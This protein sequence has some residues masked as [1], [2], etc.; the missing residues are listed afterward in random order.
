ML[1]VGRLSKI[2]KRVLAFVVPAVIGVVAA[3][4][5]V[6]IDRV[7]YLEGPLPVVLL[8]IGLVVGVIAAGVASI[9]S[10]SPPDHEAVASESVAT[11]AGSGTEQRLAMLSKLHEVVSERLLAIDER[12]EDIT[13]DDTAVSGARH[14]L[15]RLERFLLDVQGVA[16]MH[17]VRPDRVELD[18]CDLVNAVIE[19]TARAAGDRTV[20]PDLPTDAAG[21]RA[22]R[23]LMTL[24]LANLIVNAVKFSDSDAP[25]VVRVVDHPDRVIFEVEDHGPGVQDGEDVWG[26][27]ARGSNADGVPGAGLGLPLVRLIAEAH[28]GTA[29]L[30]SSSAGT[31]AAV[32]VPRT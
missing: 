22:D 21:L 18:P 2:D 23:R 13:G 32:E 14:E 28:G 9:L 25:I 30:R 6:S 20:K 4:A 31:I 12:L 27:L 29:T 15:E 24:A 7:A 19:K 3:L 5:T 10:S 11:V 16:S 26:E 1:L 17:D 8:T